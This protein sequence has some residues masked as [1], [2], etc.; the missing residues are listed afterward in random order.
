MHSLYVYIFFRPRPFIFTFSTQFIHPFF[1]L[2]LVTYSSSSLS[3]YSFRYLHIHLFAL[4]S[5]QY[6]LTSL[7]TFLNSWSWLNST[8]NFCWVLVAFVSPFIKQIS[9]GKKKS[10]STSDRPNGSFSHLPASCLFLGNRSHFLW[11]LNLFVGEYY[12]VTPN[13]KSRQ[14]KIWTGQHLYFTVIL[15]VWSLSLRLLWQ[16][17]AFSGAVEVPCVIVAPQT[18][19]T[20]AV[21]IPRA[22]TNLS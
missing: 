4:F 7:S 8:L 21:N 6:V 11:G 15:T 19:S 12:H 18:S 10:L 13:N 14:N 3:P 16:W 20:C 1:S 2:F 5:E 22:C 9:S 17:H